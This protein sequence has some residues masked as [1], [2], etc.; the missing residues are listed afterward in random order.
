ME[1]FIW[2]LLGLVGSC[3]MQIID[4]SIIFYVDRYRD[5]GITLLRV[6]IF[7]VSILFGPS[8]FVMAMI[9]II[10]FVCSS[11]IM[12]KTIYTIKRK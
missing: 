10:A 8:T 4:I 6:T 2:F 12:S 1:L 9:M 5:I 3:M 7:L 11:N